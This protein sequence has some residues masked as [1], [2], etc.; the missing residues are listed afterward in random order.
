M[1]E[2]NVCARAGAI[3]TARTLP[4]HTPLAALAEALEHALTAE[5]TLLGSSA[6]DPAI[7]D[8]IRGA[9]QA[10]CRLG[11]TATAVLHAG[12]RVGEAGLFLAGVMERAVAPR[13]SDAAPAFLR[14]A[15]SLV[16]ETQAAAEEE[17]AHRRLLMARL[18]TGLDAMARLDL[19]GG[20]QRACGP[21]VTGDA[22]TALA[23]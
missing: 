7:D 5:Q 15:L 17:I 14:A 22:L 18:V 23:A 10:W 4:H 19:F 16:P 2:A 11:R 20:E 8:A 9:E 12:S 1:A 21:Q 6:A 3:N 13:D